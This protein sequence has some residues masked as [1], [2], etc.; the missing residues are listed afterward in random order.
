MRR[1]LTDVATLGARIGVGGIFFANG[2]DKLEAGLNATTEQFAQQGAPLPNV[3]AAL[4]MLIELLGGAMLIAGFAVPVCGILLF[5]EALAVFV[6]ASG[7]Q[8]RPLTGGDTNLIV[9]LGAATILLAVVGAGRVSVDHMVVIKRRETYDAPELD[10]DAEADA[11]LA[12]LREPRRSQGAPGAHSP[13]SAAASGTDPAT[14]PGSASGSAAGLKAT[15]RRRDAEEKSAPAE[16]A[17]ASAPA[18]GGGGAASS[19]AAES[20]PKAR[21]PRQRRTDTGSDT[22][23]ASPSE[24]P[25]ATEKGD[26]LVAGRR[27]GT[28]G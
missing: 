18:D 19:A 11:M 28:T 15:A 16:P 20:A 5:V 8:G 26:K 9:A 27:E 13:G 4:S 21:K 22:T 10:P 14:A 12:A 1:I 23:T 3:W 17:A 24:A 25:A 6:V 7:E 2:W